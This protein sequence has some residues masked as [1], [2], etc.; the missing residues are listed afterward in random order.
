VYSD[1]EFTEGVWRLPFRDGRPSGDLELLKGGLWGM[2]PV[3]VS[4]SRFAYGLR[5]EARQIHLTSIDLKRNRIGTTYTPVEETPRESRSPA[6]SADGRWLAYTTDELMRGGGRVRRLIVQPLAGGDPREI[7]PEGFSD[8]Q[9]ASWA[10]GDRTLV[11]LA[12]RWGQQEGGWVAIDMETGK[13][14]FVARREDLVAAGLD[15]EPFI[16]GLFGRF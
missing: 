9:Y 12:G 3:G 5:T 7:A 10:N 8:F 1:R 11:A 2:Q 16:R 13:A 15:P 6:W 4:G 14:T